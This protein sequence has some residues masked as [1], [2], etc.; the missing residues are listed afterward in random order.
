M[1][2]K[3]ISEK[4][5]KYLAEISVGVISSA[6]FDKLIALYE[7]EIKT[8]Y[9]TTS[10]EANL[11]RIIQ[12]MYDKISFIKDCI[13]YP[14]YLEI[15]ISISVNSNYLTDILIINPEYFYWIVNPSILKTKLDK[16]KFNKEIVV[17][18][19]RKR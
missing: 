6:D 12:G 8:Y 17:I 7:S 1:R 3:K 4:F 13:S 9:F 15:L 19:Y 10:S 5:E 14:H 16:T 18:K 2:L 11:I